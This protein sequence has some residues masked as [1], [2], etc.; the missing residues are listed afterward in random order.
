MSDDKKPMQ[1]SGSDGLGAELA[2][3]KDK[4]SADRPEPPGSAVPV[5]SYREWNEEALEC[6][7][8]G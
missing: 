6:P 5:N 7:E 8:F 2:E 3:E 1:A 4:P